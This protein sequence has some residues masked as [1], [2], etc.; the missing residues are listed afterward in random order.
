LPNTFSAIGGRS[1]KEGG[2]KVIAST[3]Y[4]QSSYGFQAC[5]LIFG[6]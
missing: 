6:K 3:G 5:F 2:I 4:G 1:G